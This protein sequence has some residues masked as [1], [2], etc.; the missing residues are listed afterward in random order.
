MPSIIAQAKNFVNFCVNLM[1]ESVKRDLVDKV[2]L[3]NSLDF[4]RQ[5]SSPT[6]TLTEQSKQPEAESSIDQPE[7]DKDELLD[8]ESE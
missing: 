4:T 2:L 8:E 1:D 6:K 3:P 5:E 7:E